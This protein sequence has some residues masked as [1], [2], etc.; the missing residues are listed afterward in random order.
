LEAE[1]KRYHEKELKEEELKSEMQDE[2]DRKLAS[3]NKKLE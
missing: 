3:V 2:F 1:K